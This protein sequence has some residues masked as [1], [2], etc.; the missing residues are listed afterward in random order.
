MAVTKRRR[1]PTQLPSRATNR[2]I[3]G[4]IVVE[5]TDLRVSAEI[6]DA[7]Q[8]TK[9]QLYLT[10]VLFLAPIV[11]YMM[12]MAWLISVEWSTY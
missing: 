12:I 4:A 6:A 5:R 9:R 11:I 7:N 2:R 3:K 1:R 10:P 8:L